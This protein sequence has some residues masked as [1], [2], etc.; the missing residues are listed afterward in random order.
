MEYEKIF[1]KD[2]T[3][4]DNIQ[5]IQTA[6]TT[7]YEKKKKSIQKKGQKIWINIFPGRHTDVKQEHKNGLNIADY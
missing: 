7:W 3:N 4:K 1:A 6:H 2:G 5:K